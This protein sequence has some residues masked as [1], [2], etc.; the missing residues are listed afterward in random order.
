MLLRTLITQRRTPAAHRPEA[1][2]GAEV[3]VARK[4]KQFSYNFKRL[5]VCVTSVV[6]DEKTYRCK[7]PGNERIEG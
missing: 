5:A 2:G 4:K 6:C 1:E 3:Q 7:G